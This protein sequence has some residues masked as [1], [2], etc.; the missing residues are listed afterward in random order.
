MPVTAEVA[1][2]CCSACDGRK[3]SSAQEP[4]LFDR[5]TQRWSTLTTHAVGDPTWSRDGRFVYFQD[6]VEKGKPVYRI[7]VPDGKP[8]LVANID[9][10]RPVAATDY[11]LI[12]LAPGDLP[13]VQA[14]TPVVNLYEINM[15]GN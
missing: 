10:L 7:T 11:R 1:A 14:S 13:L 8:E 9:N 3:R 15:N 2:P 4:L 6:F 5:A 12:G